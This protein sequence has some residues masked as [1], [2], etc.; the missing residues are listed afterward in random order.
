MKMVRLSALHTGCLCSQEMFLVLI[1]VRGWVDPRAIV[2][3]EGLCHWKLPMT[4][5]GIGHVMFRLV[6]HCLNQL[7]YCI[8]PNQGMLFWI[9][10]YFLFL[11]PLPLHTHTHSHSHVCTC[12]HVYSTGDPCLTL[13]RQN[14]IPPSNAACRIFL[15]GILN[16]IAHS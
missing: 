2:W 8:P 6:A 16:F 3:Q 4:A 12:M 11:P 13:W 9:N 5:S 14:Y 15:L 1:S 10:T 7:C